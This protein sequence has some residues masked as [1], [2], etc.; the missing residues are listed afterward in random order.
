MS[1]VT[2]QGFLRFRADLVCQRLEMGSRTVWVLKDPFSRSLQYVSDDEFAILGMVDGHRSPQQL[3][4]ECSKRFATRFMS[5]ES[6]VHFLADAKRRKLLVETEV[7]ARRTQNAN[8][9]ADK[10]LAQ[11][12][13]WWL[14]FLA[15]RLPGIRPDWILDA[16][17][18]LVRWLFTPLACVVYTSCVALAAAIAMSQWD[19]IADHVS[20]AFLNRGAAAVLPFFV[21]MSAVK[22]VHELAHAA[23]CKAFGGDCRELGVMLLFGMP[24]L[25]CDVSDAWIMPQRYKRILVSAAGMLAE[26]GIAALAMFAWLWTGDAI[27][28]EWWLIVMVVCSVSTIVVNGNPLMRYDGYFILS[29]VVGIPNLGTRASLALREIVRNRLWGERTSALNNED[30]Q[31]RFWLAVYAVASQIYR[32]I[33]ILTLASMVSRFAFGSGIAILGTTFAALLVVGTVAPGLYAAIRPPDRLFRSQNRTKRSLFPIGVLLAFI[34]LLII[35]LPRSVVAPMTIRP[36][37]S[38]DLFAT[39]G[40]RLTSCVQDGSLVKVGD[41]IAT[42]ANPSLES[43]LLEA[44]ANH[45]S[46]MTTR[47]SLNS[48]RLSDSNHSASLTTLTA[49]EEAALERVKLRQEEYR[50]LTLAAPADGMI[51]APTRNVGN[52]DSES[53][54]VRW[55]ETLLDQVN[56]GAWIK[57]GTVIGSIGDSLQREAILYVDQKNALLVEVGQEVR[58]LLPHYMGKPWTG[59]VIEVGVTPV[60]QCAPELVGAGLVAVD[61]TTEKGRMAIPRDTLYQV[62]VSV[63]E[64]SNPMPVRTIGSAQ[65]QVARSSI[66][67]RLCRLLF[68]SFRF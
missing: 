44:E 15:I 46:L 30:N 18:P 36:A 16:V 41:P 21:V 24:C 35:P 58:I 5:P 39:V 33:V 22:I 57:P 14:N 19:A 64:S 66:M 67:T 61:L 23:A 45:R 6:L 42:L 4:L 28:R 12:K 48:R 29:D 31:C 60:T 43:A 26:I 63:E 2:P 20:E 56:L 38:Q 51:F 3:L 34:G 55:N 52:E 62:R 49:T 17:Y 37:D 8:L 10:S 47:K 11:S 68:Q 25:Y 50:K 53:E 1:D 54:S 65:V 27:L 9:T 59:L 13:S 40:G 32:V 7:H